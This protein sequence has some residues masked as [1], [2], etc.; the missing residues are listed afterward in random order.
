MQLYEKYRPH[1]FSDVL[2]QRRAMRQVNTVLRQE[3]GG[4]A[5]WLSGASG[6]GKTTIARIIAAQGASEFYV[7]EY[8]SADKLDTLALSE[9]EQTMNLY[10]GGKG[11]RAYI[12][13]EA[14]GLRKP[15]IRRL[16]GLLERLPSHVVF[17]F[18][19]TKIGQEGLFEAQIDASPLLSR[20]A[21]IELTNQGLA[22]V[23][24]KH[25]Q[26]IAKTEKLDGKP[27]QAYVKLAQHCKNNCREMLMAV[28]T[29]KMFN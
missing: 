29:G 21:Y 13:N 25:C 12:V 15:I 22:G 18:T 17:I 24:S 10:G 3:W 23:F 27:I 28:E 4:R 2:G 8:D 14:H 6:T 16:L 5:W 1:E 19:T 26:Q 20:C 7:Q 11:G 9:I